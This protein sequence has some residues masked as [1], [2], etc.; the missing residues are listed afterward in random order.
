MSAACLQS[1]FNSIIVLYRAG[2]SKSRIAKELHIPFSRVN[3]IIKVN[4]GK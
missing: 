1:Y 2:Y 4:Y 3:L